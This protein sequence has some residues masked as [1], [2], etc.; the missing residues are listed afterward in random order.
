MAS[1]Q[2][3]AKGSGRIRQVRQAFRCEGSGLRS[4]VR[5]VP[6]LIPAATAAAS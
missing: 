4:Q 2:T 3:A 5:A 1:L 6:T